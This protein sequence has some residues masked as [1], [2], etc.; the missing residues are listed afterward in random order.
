MKLLFV[1]HGETTS[2]INGIVQS[3]ADPLTSL[4]QQQALQI[5]Q[6]LSKESIDI[7]YSSSHIRCQ[8]TARVIHPFH[9]DIC[10]LYSD[11]LGEIDRGVFAGQERTHEIDLILQ[12]HNLTLTSRPPNGESITDVA[13]RAQQFI[14]HILLYHSNET[15][16]IVGH[17][18]FLKQLQ[19][20]FDKRPLQDINII[21]NVANASL[22]ERHYKETIRTMIQ[23]NTTEFL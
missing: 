9:P 10:L 18:W 11:L 13:Q 4:W 14:E 17:S 22:S 8:E 15:V 12:E 7:I 6:R 1:R 2:N 16:L 3:I 19:I 23:Y 21:K 20:I 5:A